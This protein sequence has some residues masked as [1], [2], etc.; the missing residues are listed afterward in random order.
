VTGVDRR[1][2]PA[3]AS[4]LAAQGV[5]LVL[6]AEPLEAIRGCELLVLSPG[7]HL[8]HPMVVE[9]RR[10]GIETIGELEL[11]ASR[12][13]APMLAVTGTNGKSTTTTLCAHL[14][15]RAGRNVFA[16]GNLGLPLLA[17][18]EGPAPDWAVVEVSSYQLE[19]LSRP[20]AIIPSIAIWLNLTPD[21]L[22]RHGTLERYAACKRRLF[23]AQGPRESGVFFADDEVVRANAEGL[24]C[25][26]R[27]FARDV[28][29]LRPGDVWIQGRMLSA[30]G[31]DRQWRLPSDR[32]IGDHNAENAASAILAALEAGLSPEA[33]QAGLDDFVGLP[34][35]LELVAEQGGVR[36]VND[37]KGTNVDAAARS[38]A[39][40][41]SAG[42]VWIA[43][44]RGKGAPYGPL[45]PLVRQNVRHMILLGEDA[46]SLEAELGDCAPA[47]RVEDLA[48]AVAVARRLA[49]PGDVVLLS[50]ACAS[51]DM[52][53]DFEERGDEFRRLVREGAETP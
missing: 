18:L 29:R 36:F 43:G 16:G 46:P 25:R 13:A 33:I 45:R 40:F 31:Q 9:A 42:I 19:H 50:P 51:F 34:H 32:L 1:E 38:L 17:A 2:N 47:V 7:V 15:R 53:R 48:Q 22:D 39:S 21:H 41:G 5:E 11:A 4:A 10:Q 35:R 27:C 6:G 37:S 14:L 26:R 52:F 44:G 3:D 23:E 30:V 12:L 8:D 24:S 20:G 49:R 28:G